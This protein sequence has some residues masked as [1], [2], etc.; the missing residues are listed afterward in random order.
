MLCGVAG[1]AAALGS[2]ATV[3]K[4]W[5]GGAWGTSAMAATKKP[6]LV[7]QMG[8]WWGMGSA[9]DKAAADEKCRAFAPLI[10]ASARGEL[11]G[12]EWESHDGLYAQ[13]HKLRSPR[14]RLVYLHKPHAIAPFRA[15]D[16]AVRPAQPQ[17]LPR[18]LGGLLVRP[19]RSGD[20]ARHR[21]GRPPPGTG[22]RILHIPLHPRCV[23]H[24]LPIQIEIDIDIFQDPYM[25]MTC[26]I[27]PAGYHLG[28]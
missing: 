26:A 5:F 10:R 18:H 19:T 7:G 27:V 1:E 8:L 12:E 28:Q 16:A 17:R 15:A 11:L 22:R 13:V 6:P 14:P 2:P 9:E 25:D 3:L 23:P 21:E 4:F 20:G 24:I